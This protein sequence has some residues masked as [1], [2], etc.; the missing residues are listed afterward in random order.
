[1]ASEYPMFDGA[2]SE[3]T[4]TNGSQTVTGTIAFEGFGQTVATTGSSSNPYMFKGGF[5]YRNDGDAGLHHVGA[6]YYDAQT[7]RFINR[8]TVLTE[9]PYLYCEHNPISLADPSGHFAFAPA[10]PYAIS[11][12]MALY[13][14]YRAAQVIAGLGAIL[15]AGGAVADAIR[16][17][18]WLSQ[19]ALPWQG[20][21]GSTAA[22]D[23]GHGHGQIRD[24]GEDGYPDIDFDFGHDHGAGD[25]H[26]HDIG[27][28]PGGGP[29]TH[30]DRG[31]GRPIGP[32]E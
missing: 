4:V 12:G 7:G 10:I 8:D 30:L 9:H 32:G 6:R 23:D 31:P 11:A 16:Q 1:M 21:P 25:P 3:R 18:H 20:A 17:N 26:A 29:P 19:R 2:G 5:G 15:L 22:R 24:Y 27:R 28:P 13:A 14:A